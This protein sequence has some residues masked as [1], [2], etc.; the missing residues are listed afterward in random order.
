[1][2]N[3]LQKS[4]LWEAVKKHVL[5]HW[6]N[7]TIGMYVCMSFFSR[8][9]LSNYIFLELTLVISANGKNSFFV[10]N[11]KMNEIKTR[12]RE[13]K[14]ILSEKFYLKWLYWGYMRVSEFLKK[15][16]QQ[17]KLWIKFGFLGC[18]KL[19]VRVFLCLCLTLSR[20]ILTKF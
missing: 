14:K 6:N 11:V 12:G 20:N 17:I 18:V 19:C 2:S 9:K 3:L 10:F 8:G 16:D 4:L 15:F 5:K 7:S 13:R 1:M